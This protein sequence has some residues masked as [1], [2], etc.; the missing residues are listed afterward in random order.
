MWVDVLVE[1]ILAERPAP[2][3]VNDSWT[4][5]GLVH[6]GSLRGVI[7]HDALVRGLREQGAEVRFL[8]GFDDY[9]PFD[10]IPPGLPENLLRPHLGKP[11]SEVPW[12]DATAASF[13]HRYIAEFESIIRAVGGGCTFY[14]TSDLYRSGQFDGA[15]R[16][17]LDRAEEI[18]RIEREITGSTRAE[19]HPVQ[20]VCEACGRI[21]TTAVL[22]W[23]GREVAYECRPD[24]VTWARGCGYRGRRSPFRGGAK[25]TFRT[26]WAAKWWIFGVR[27]EGAGKDHMTRGGTHDTASAVARRIFGITPPFPIPYE[28]IYVGGKKMSG[29]AGRGVPARDLLEV[30]RPQLVRFLIVRAHHRTAI[31][32]DPRGE[33]VPRLYDEYDRAAAAYF[34]ELRPRTPGEAEDIRDLARTFRYAWLRDTPPEPF[35]RP[36]FAK[37]AY[38][39]QMPHVDLEAAVARE[40]GAPLTDQDREELRA[41]VQDARRWLERWAPDRYRFTVQ[42]RLPEAARGLSPAQRTLLARLADFLEREEPTGEAVQARIHA[43]K[44]ELGLSPEQ[45]FGALYLSF[46]GKPSGPQAGWMLAALD[47]QFV[48]QRLREASQAVPTPAS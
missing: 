8:Y 35:Y 15:L 27:V 4:P 28:W 32:F 29:S 5:S 19:R 26:E 1:A 14:R 38:L 13:A 37:L 23:D 40:K 44:A 33:T 43:L 31:E 21:A 2:Y 7:L 20:V 17:V 3:V 30:L 10:A 34:G 22:G 16:V 45:A 36:R 42:V 12:V 11:L 41:R 18:V 25:M 46:L 9:D 39:V 24:K 48:V 47:R 6:V